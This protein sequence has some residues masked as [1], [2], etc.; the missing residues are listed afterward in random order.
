MQAT[1]PIEVTADASPIVSVCLEEDL[2]P[3]LFP[4]RLIHSSR[5]RSGRF[6]LSS[7]MLNDLRLAQMLIV[8]CPS[9][10]W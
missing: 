5:L 2:L 7:S 1:R 8:S 6:K 9:D 10:A 3:C 4:V